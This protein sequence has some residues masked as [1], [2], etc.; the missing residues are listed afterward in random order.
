MGE[1]TELLGLYW[2]LSGPVE[3]HTGREWSLFDI[4]D[5]CAEAER[6]GFAGIGLWH[7]DLEHILETRTLSDLKALLDDHGLTQLELEFLQDWFVDPGDERRI[8]SDA[9]R[10]LLFDAAEVL[11]PHHI[12][13]GNIPG[14]P[15]E[16]AKLAERFAEL[17]A[18]AATRTDARIV[19]EFMPFDVNV[20]DVDSAL[21]LLG[22]AGAGNGA[23][24]VDT[25]HMSKLGIAPGDLRRFS[26]QQIGWV[27]LSDGRFADMDDPIDEV[28]NHRRL[29]GEGEFD[30]R[31]YVE[32]CRDIG[33]PG[34]WGVEVLSEDLRNRPMP[35]IF[36]RAYETTAAQF[37][38]SSAEVA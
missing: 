9:T 30:I 8:A 5:R 29:P 2:T 17:C 19:Y 3:V 31:G 28:V 36:R 20:H 32:V 34:P 15:C 22:T 27:E 37:S 38:G 10:R 12:K 25:W 11:G 24:A 14:T 6:A 13:V 4:A 35:E 1:R 26:A 16:P 33:Y 18:D 21:A 23:V 7:A